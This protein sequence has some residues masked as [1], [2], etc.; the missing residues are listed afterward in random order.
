[1]TPTVKSEVVFA[2][3]GS[4]KTELLSKRYL[5][6]VARGV[7]PERILTITFT[8]KA[9]A[10]M[11]KRILDRAR[12]SNPELYRI[13]QDNI[14]RLRISTIHSFCFSLVRRFA[15]LLGLD[16]NLDVLNDPESLWLQTKYDTLMKI[17]E[18][19]RG[20]T[21]YQFLIDLITSDTRQGWSK[22]SDNL[23]YLY[24][25]RNAILRGRVPEMNLSR[26]NNLIS[27]LKNHPTGTALIPDYQGIFPTD[28]D[29]NTI[30]KALK[31]VEKHREKFLTR[32]GDPRK[33]GL[34]EDERPWAEKMAD[35]YYELHNIYAYYKV[36]KEFHLFKERFLATYEQAKRELGQVDFNDMELLTLELIR[37]NPD[38]LNILYA[39]DENTDH[40]LVDEFQDTSFLQWEII[41]KLT[42]EWRAGEGAKSAAGITPSIFI[43]GDDKQS[44]YMFRGANVEVFSRA[45]T[46]LEEWLKEK[47][48][49]TQLK[50]N[51]RSLPAI[52]NFT[53]TLFA[54]LMNAQPGDPPW[55][56]RYAAFRC[57]RKAASRGRVEIILEPALIKGRVDD[58]RKMDAQ[59]VAR[60]INSLIQSG[61]E[62]F[63]GQPDNTEKPRP[64]EYSDIAILI[65]SSRQLP[66]IEMALR[67]AEIPFLVVGGSGFYQEDEVRYLTSLTGFLIDPGDDICLYIT[68]RSPLF[69]VPEGELFLASPAMDSGNHPPLIL[70]ERVKRFARPGTK[71]AEAVAILE[72]AVARVYHQPLSLLLDRLLSQTHAYEKFWEPQREAN[73]RKFLRIVQDM[74][75][76]GTHPL[77]IKNF[78]ESPPSEEA[79][80]DVTTT[81][82]NVVQIMTVHNAKGLQFPIVFHPGLHEK[83]LLV[84]KRPEMLIEERDINEVLIFPLS[85]AKKG[86]R[87]S[88]YDTYKEK[89]V[90]EEKRIFYVACTRARDA[91]FL[92]GV[93]EPNLLESDTRLSWLVTHLGLHQTETG[94]CL[95]P[96]IPD[97]HCLASTEITT[98][99]REPLTGAA[100]GT[101]LHQE[102]K[103]PVV[104]KDPLPP[105]LLPRVASVTRYTRQDLHRDD[106]GENI[107]LGDALH[108]LLQ[109]ISNGRLTLEHPNLSKEITRLLRRAS[110]PPDR[111][112]KLTHRIEEQLQRLARSPVWEIIK[113]QP[114]AYAELPIIYNDGKTIW[115]GR[116]DRLIVASDE[117]RIYDYKT[118]PVKKTEIVKLK[119]EYHR[120][121]LVH[122]ARAVQELYPDKKVKTFLVFTSLPEV[123]PAD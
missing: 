58:Y 7:K 30:N 51:Y 82:M 77:R 60:R 12:E 113:P 72:P 19:E 25:N 63:Q 117:V 49:R 14:L 41:D 86:E 33:R 10:E 40:L 57:Q 89:A 96:E 42:E 24:N 22:F 107:P 48:K 5:K 31:L 83:I 55:K 104:N 94:F 116:I 65:R 109:L 6:L 99:E 36:K 45:A 81:G 93:W 91:L 59:I 111:Q 119:E 3:A 52:I 11:K 46:K 15:D 123:V 73:I 105:H 13:L 54:K 20:T 90:E 50:N 8:D 102:E 68:L 122:Y 103:P 62:V 115:T 70:W 37:D 29:E 100:A 80:A 92:T 16:P 47:I 39:F 23:Q 121:Q 64:C 2:P 85:R 44:I 118:F 26:L 78:L 43:V 21:E 66:A 61:Y 34:K 69:A 108:E 97:V 114:N 79:K 87:F 112:Q 74:E 4:G 67:E 9:A 95:D 98:R 56:T 76:N 71:L 75:T 84:N 35:Y 27:E 101:A 18:T 88:I 53:N 106:Q 110:L 32:Q 38:W 120:A 28:F 17:A 1:M